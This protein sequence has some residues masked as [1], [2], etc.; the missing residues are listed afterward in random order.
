MT[1]LRRPSTWTL[2]AKLVASV[3]L[4]FL[5]VTALTGTL[6]GLAARQYLT[7]QVDE[8]L[9]SASARFV[10]AIDGTQPPGP[11][12]QPRGGLPAPAE[13]RS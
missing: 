13:M 12:G 3:L 2:R 9:Q 11:A 8:D 10:G 1:S 5:A 7:Q 4:L 6:T